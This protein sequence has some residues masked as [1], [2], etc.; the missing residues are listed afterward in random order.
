MNDF[1]WVCSSYLLCSSRRPQYYAD[2]FHVPW[3]F[4]IS[5]NEINWKPHFRSSEIRKFPEWSLLATSRMIPILLSFYIE[6]GEANFTVFSTRHQHFGTFFSLLSLWA[7]LCEFCL[8]TNVPHWFFLT[9]YE[10]KRDKMNPQR[11]WVFPRHRLLNIQAPAHTGGNNR[12]VLMAC[13]VN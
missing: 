8:Q 4:I 3:T 11:L 13:H 5:T 9:T 1:T 6:R 7:Y 12:D 10:E 2:G